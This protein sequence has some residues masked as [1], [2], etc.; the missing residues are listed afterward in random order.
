MPLRVYRPNR[1][2]YTHPD[3]Q[4]FHKQQSW[5][6]RKIM[7]SLTSKVDSF[8]N[9]I[10]RQIVTGVDDQRMPPIKEQPRVLQCSHYQQ[11][12]RAQRTASTIKRLGAGANGVEPMRHF[13][14]CISANVNFPAIIG[15]VSA[16]RP[17]SSGPGGS[18]IYG[19]DLVLTGRDN[20]F[21]HYRR[22]SN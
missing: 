8:F 1:F 10:W 19:V 6:G 18:G 5:I 16:E 14:R 4:L 3:A 11:S 20:R 15:V 17:P 9:K 22:A 7:H 12:R 13:P 21:R 2:C